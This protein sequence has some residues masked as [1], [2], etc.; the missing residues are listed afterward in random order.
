LSLVAQILPTSLSGIERYREH[1]YRSPIS[2]LFLLTIG[3][4]R[5][6]RG[7]DGFRTYGIT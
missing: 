3:T 5:F 2:W 1:G 7:Q 4:A 6:D